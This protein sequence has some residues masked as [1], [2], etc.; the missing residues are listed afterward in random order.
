MVSCR[1]YDSDGVSNDCSVDDSEEDSDD[2]PEDDS[3]DDSDCGSDDNFVFWSSV[4][5]QR[6]LVSC[7]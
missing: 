5:D 4:F 6:S 2:D 3:D 1:S 7:L